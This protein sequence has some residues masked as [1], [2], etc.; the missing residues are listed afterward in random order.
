MGTA[1]TD[2]GDQVLWG[3][4]VLLGTICG[5]PQLSL[6]E[7]SMYICGLCLI[8]PN[9]EGLTICNGAEYARDDNYGLAQGWLLYRLIRSIYTYTYVSEHL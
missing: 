7:T 8:S 1:I 2:H 6:A 9:T 4:Q 5:G 3:Y